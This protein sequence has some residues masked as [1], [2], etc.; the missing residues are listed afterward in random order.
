MSNSIAFVQARIELPELTMYALDIFP[1]VDATSSLA[2][3]SADSVA[4]VME[5]T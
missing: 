2:S 5:W 1:P 4:N 3:F